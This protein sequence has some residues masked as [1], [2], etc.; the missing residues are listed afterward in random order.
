MIN[1]NENIGIDI[2]MG[3]PNYK[4][5]ILENK[6][7]RIETELYKISEELHPKKCPYVCFKALDSI[8]WLYISIVVNILFLKQFLQ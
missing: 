3:Y 5:K 8:G 2:E 4:I 6:L 7:N 1:D